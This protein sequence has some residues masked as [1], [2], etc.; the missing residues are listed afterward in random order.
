MGNI[1]VTWLRPKE[2]SIDVK[3]ADKSFVASCGF[4]TYSGRWSTDYREF[5]NAKH[6]D[7]FISYIERTKGYTF[8]EVW[9]KE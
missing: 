4:I 3:Y 6:L 2:E 1:K 8:D 5:K 7:N 9:V